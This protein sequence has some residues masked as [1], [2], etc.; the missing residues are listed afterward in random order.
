MCTQP[1]KVKH[2][3]RKRPA[4]YF[5]SFL[6]VFNRLHVLSRKK[7]YPR[8]A[9]DLVKRDIDFFKQIIERNMEQSFHN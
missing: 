9:N 8:L 3:L 2:F 7:P 6:M 1:C 5:L 4:S